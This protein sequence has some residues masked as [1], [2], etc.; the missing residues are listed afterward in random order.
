LILDQI[1]E[2]GVWIGAL[3]MNLGEDLMYFVSNGHC[4]LIFC[5][6]EAFE[7]NQNLITIP[8]LSSFF[9]ILWWISN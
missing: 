2:F 8:A 9:F 3:I 7:G 4:L 6:G 5:G 1:F